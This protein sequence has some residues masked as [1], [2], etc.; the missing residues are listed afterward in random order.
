MIAHQLRVW[1]HPEIRRAF[2]NQEHR[3]LGGH[4]DGLPEQASRF[5]ARID[6]WAGLV[7]DHYA[8]SDPIDLAQ[9]WT[10][11]D[12]RGAF[13]AEATRLEADLRLALGRRWSVD[14]SPEPGVAV[15]RLMGEC[16]SEWPLWNW[17]G[18]SE[19]RRWPM[20]SD[21]LRRHLTQW[22]IQ[23]E[24]DH[25]PQPDPVLTERLAHDVRQELGPRFLV[26]VRD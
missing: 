18:A 2:A 15:V 10:S 12:A 25:V 16:S 6:E 3:I 1:V 9:G 4:D 5:A 20:L 21:R 17:E 26:E 13:V 19:S 22:A 23:A 24:P 7:R 8:I 14:V 11:E